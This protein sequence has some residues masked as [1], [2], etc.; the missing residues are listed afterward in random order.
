[1]NRSVFVWGD[2]VL[3]WL[4]VALGVAVVSSLI[5]L[6]SVEVFVL[7]F[8][9]DHPRLPV[10]LFGLVIAIGQVAGKLLYFY[11]AR[12]S[13]RLPAFVHRRS[14]TAN[15]ARDTAVDR[16][17][18]SRPKAVWRSVVAWVRTSWAWLRDRCHRHP[19]WMITATASSALIGVPPFLATTVLAGLAG[20]SLRAF[21]AASFPARFARF[22]MLAA[23]PHWVMHW[24]PAIHHH[25][26]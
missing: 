22:T 21:V 20:L 24:L 5:P 18:C 17:P 8:A 4:L 10:V 16:G 23:A 26:H 6:V 9:A 19:G 25:A 11:A 7:A 14:A 13:L 3:T 1:V 12:G 15:T 2:T